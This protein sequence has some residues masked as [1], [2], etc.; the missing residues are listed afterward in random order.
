[1]KK[2]SEIGRDM[3]VVVPANGEAAGFSQE[4]KAEAFQRIQVQYLNTDNPG[5]FYNGKFMTLEE[6]REFAQRVWDAGYMAAA[7][8]D[9]NCDSPYQTF[10]EFMKDEGL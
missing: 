7:A 6:R 4:Y 10:E 2:L 9:G 5:Q 1:M 3:W 8:A